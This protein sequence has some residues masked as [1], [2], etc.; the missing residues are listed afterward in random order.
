MTD[1]KESKLEKKDDKHPI[2]EQKQQLPKIVEILR[3]VRGINNKSMLSAIVPNLNNIEGYLKLME[4][5]KFE[6]CDLDDE[7][8]ELN[9]K[10]IMESINFMKNLKVQDEDKKV[11]GLVLYFGYIEDINEKSGYK[12][13]F[14]TF[15]I[16]KDCLKS[17]MILGNR[18]KMSYLYKNPWFIEEFL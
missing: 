8:N 4:G 9:L 12:K 11:L 13:I 18:F 17:E 3:D 10:M 16:P 14:H 6:A 15:P 5:I 2:L 7:E 1:I